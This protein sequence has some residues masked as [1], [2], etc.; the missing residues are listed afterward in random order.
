MTKRQNNWFWVF[1]A[2]Y[3]LGLLFFTLIPLLVS[4]YLSFCKYD[5]YNPPQW[6]GLKN[7]IAMLSAPR[8]WQAFRNIAIFTVLN[9]GIKIPLACILAA[10]LNSKLKSRPF[11]RVV[12][13]LPYLTPTVAIVAIWSIMYNP[14]YGL[15]N[16][17]FGLIGLG[18]FEYVFS[19]KYLEFIA[20]VTAMV[21]WQGIG[22][23]IVFLGAGLQNI[24]GDLY[25]AATIDGATAVKKFTKITLPLLSPT[26]FFLVIAGVSS[27]FQVFDPFYLFDSF[28]SF[29]PVPNQLMYEYVWK[30]VNRVGQGAALGWI[31]FMIVGIIT[32]CMRRAE[33]WVHYE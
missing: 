5:M 2:P 20:S 28:G 32:F 23:T 31:S 30:G 9:E 12:F 17:L 33:R 13:F 8:T 25:E 24:S 19:T 27:S 18:P 29:A 16:Y 4:I 14:A 1:A 6:I 7:Y 3:V 11:F 15:F 22:Y 21:I 26:I 10:L